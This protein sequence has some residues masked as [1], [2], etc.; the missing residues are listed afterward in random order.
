MNRDA[1]VNESAPTEATPLRLLLVDDHAVMRSG[2]AN[3]L[4]ARDE[5]SVVAEAGNGNEAIE[6]YESERPDLTL[7]DVVMPDIGGIECLRK[8]KAAS[9]E[10]LILMLSSSELEHD[11]FQAMESGADGY[12][13]K[14]ASPSE[15]VQSILSVARGETYT[16]DE[17]SQRLADYSDAPQLSPRELEVI[18]LL[19]NGMSNAR[20]GEELKITPRTAKAHVASILLKLGAKDRT[21]AVARGFE[22]GLLR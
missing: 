19:R 14:T 17:I 15:L 1:E 10:A 2:L 16:S 4:N 11:I 8:I 3:M 21:E 6:L 5:F 20:I 18:Q 12:I 7:M 9:P 13:T 22:Q